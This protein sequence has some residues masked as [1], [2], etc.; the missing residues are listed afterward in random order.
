MGLL[1]P[2]KAIVI[3]FCLVSFWVFALEMTQAPSEGSEISLLKPDWREAVATTSSTKRDKTGYGPYELQCYPEPVL[4]AWKGGMAPFVLELTATNHSKKCQFTTSNASLFVY[5]L[6]VGTSYTWTLTDAGGSKL[7]G[8]FRTALTPRL[9]A[10]PDRDA[11]P[12]NVRDI[13]GYA[14]ISGARVRQ[15]LVYR[16]S[17][18]EG[19]KNIGLAEMTPANGHVL[20]KELAIHTDLDLRYA[21]QVA[22]Y[23]ASQIAPM[24][25]WRCYAINAY[26]PF[27]PEMNELFRDTIRTFAQREYYPIYVHCSGGADRTGEICFL[28]SALLGVADEDLFL[29]Y[30]LTSLARLPRPRKMSYFQAWLKRIA[31][32]SPDEGKG[33]SYQQQTE[34]Y[35]LGIGITPQEIAAIR[36]ILLE[37]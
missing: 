29:D 9:I 15:G 14:T 31:A 18:M 34:N 17:E 19:W 8:R 30:E 13:G 35:L 11:M 26:K 21:H 2:R 4:F 16:G 6:Y 27:T 20:V 36:D 37:K 7:S 25:Q 1:M 10:F 5:N 32:F 3:L 24:V 12:I 23:T 22:K 28:V 33:L